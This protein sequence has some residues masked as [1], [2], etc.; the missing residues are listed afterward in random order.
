MPRVIVRVPSRITVRAVGDHGGDLR[1]AERV[2]MHED[3]LLEEARVHER[4]RPD[5]GAGRRHE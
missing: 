1:Q 2:A 3:L 5:L 4:R